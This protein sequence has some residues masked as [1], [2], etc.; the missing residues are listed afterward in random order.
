MWRSM[1]KV[2]VKLNSSGIRELLK[3]APISGACEEEAKK[4]QQRAG[5]GFE[6]QSRTYPERKGA[7]VIAATSEARQRNYK[8]NTLLKAMG[9]GK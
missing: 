1:S 4:I 5:E 7:A 3:S 6:V 2:K 8:D 9:G